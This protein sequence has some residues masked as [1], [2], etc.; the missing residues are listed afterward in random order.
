M[1]VVE[2]LARAGVTVGVSVAPVIPGLSDED[3]PGI[4][5]RARDAGASYAFQVLLRLPRPVDEIF[6]ARLEAALPLR[7]GKVLRRIRETRGGKMYD[8]RFDVRG[9]GEG[10]YADAIRAMFE[11][12]ATGLGLAIRERWS[13]RPTT[14][15]RPRAQ[16]P[17]F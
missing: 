10:P 16:L 1:R 4:L 6:R 3:I 14:F 8:A 5:R 13:D 17:L 11:R 9:R 12:T 15:A 7:A 2:T